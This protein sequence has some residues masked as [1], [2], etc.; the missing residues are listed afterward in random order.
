[1]KLFSNLH[2]NVGDFLFFTFCVPAA[3]NVGSTFEMFDL[4]NV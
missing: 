3:E 4:L 2:F 1:M